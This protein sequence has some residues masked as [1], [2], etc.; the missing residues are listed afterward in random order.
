MT[1]KVNRHKIAE[2]YNTT[3]DWLKTHLSTRYSST[4]KFATIEEKMMLEIKGVVFYDGK[5]YL[6]AL[7]KDDGSIDNIRYNIFVSKIKII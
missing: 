1:I 4:E 3:S 5:S 6:F 2:E 7:H